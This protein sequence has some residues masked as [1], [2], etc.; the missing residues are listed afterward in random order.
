MCRTHPC[1]LRYTYFGKP[2]SSVF[3][4]AEIVLEKL[5][6]S[7][8]DDFYDINH[9]NTS[10]FKTLYMI[11]D[12]PAVDIKGARQ[13]CLMALDFTSGMGKIIC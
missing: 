3:K 7:L 13:V 10:Y 12:N 5:V 4:N 9:D 2:H 8:Y 1:S 11:G 6:A